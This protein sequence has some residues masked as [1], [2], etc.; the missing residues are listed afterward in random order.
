MNTT[1]QTGAV[2]VQY[3]PNALLNDVRNHL[4][5]SSDAALC[6]RLDLAP[7]VMSKIRHKKLT[8]GPTLL[9]RLHE[10]TNWS[11]KDLKARMGILSPSTKSF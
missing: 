1:H 4:G 9:I 6:A 5:V 2:T 11:I 3:D 7:P 8:I 10:E